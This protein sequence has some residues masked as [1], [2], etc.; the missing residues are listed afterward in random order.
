MVMHLRAASRGE[1]VHVQD[2]LTHLRWRTPS[3]DKVSSLSL[4]PQ[5][6]SLQ[7]DKE[8]ITAK[9]GSGKTTSHFIFFF[10]GVILY[11]NQITVT[12]DGSYDTLLVNSTKLIGRKCLI[13]SHCVCDESKTWLV[14]TTEEA[15]SRPWPLRPDRAEEAT[16]SC[17]HWRPLKEIRITG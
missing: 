8:R 9:V 10:D 7:E 3:P 5:T 15:Q 16:T 13:V 17:N 11:F 12:L 1:S 14:Q 4:S 2:S 6:A